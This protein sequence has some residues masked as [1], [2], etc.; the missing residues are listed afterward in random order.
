MFHHVVENRE[1]LSHTGGE[2]HLLGLSCVTQA[3]VE[4][5]NDGIAAGPH[6]GRHVQC[7][8]DMRR[9]PHTM[10]L[11][12]SVPLSRFSGATPRSAALCFRLKVPNSG[13]STIS[14]RAS[15]G[16]TPGTVRSRSSFSR[17]MGLSRIAWASAHSACVTSRSSHVM[18]AFRRLCTKWGALPRRFFSA[19]SISMSWRRRARSAATKNRTRL[20]VA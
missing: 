16:P 5:A 1:P 15:P 3:L 13:R 4:T 2:C 7:C 17:Q 19:V 20:R 12:R 9:P 11:L 6:Q 8:P 18:C 10:R 14:V